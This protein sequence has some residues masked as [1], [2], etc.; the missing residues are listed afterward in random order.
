M[1]NSV[2]ASVIFYFRGERFSPSMTLDLDALM[3]R[4]EG[5][6]NLHRAIAIANGISIY[7]YEYE[8]MLAEEPHFDQPEGMAQEFVADGRFDIE[9]YR[10]R[11]SELQAVEK[12][13]PIAERCVGV[14][15]LEAK[16]KLKAAL[17][18]A[19]LAG[20]AAR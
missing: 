14:T 4:E 16:P 8:V 15:D 9:G 13:R 10:R 18:E 7:S 11:W 12:V 2:V 17:I 6:D 20:Q 1:K 5:L 3:A 19:Y